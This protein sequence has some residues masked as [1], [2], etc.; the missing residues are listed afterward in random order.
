MVDA[1][2]N[3]G[4]LLVHTIFTLPHVVLILGPKL[5]IQ[6]PA[7]LQDELVLWQKGRSKWPHRAMALKAS[8]RKRHPSLTFHWSRPV[9][10]G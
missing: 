7:S 1:S 2:S 4:L 10:V 6:G 3:K 8:A 5:K 9:S